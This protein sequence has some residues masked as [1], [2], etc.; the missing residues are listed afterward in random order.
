MSSNLFTFEK[1]RA[2]VT[3][4]AEAILLRKT[5]REEIRALDEKT[6][7]ADAALF[8]IEDSDDFYTKRKAQAVNI[9]TA[10]TA[11]VAEGPGIDIV[12]AAPTQTIGL[13]GD[14]ILI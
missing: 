4:L 12:T 9:A 6:T 3:E 5:G 1:L 7:L 11:Y 2:F 13:G 14:T 10:V 8:V